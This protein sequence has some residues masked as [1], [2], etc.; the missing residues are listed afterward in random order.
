MSILEK[1]FMPLPSGYVHE[2]RTMD[3][4]RTTDRQLGIVIHAAFRAWEHWNSQANPKIQG[5]SAELDS[6][7]QYLYRTIH[8]AEVFLS[9]GSNV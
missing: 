3:G 9:G 8:E 4:S 5:I 2:L 6:A 1:R 7:M